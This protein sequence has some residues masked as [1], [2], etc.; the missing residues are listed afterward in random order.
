MAITNLW[1][2]KRNV[3][4]AVCVSN[5]TE[6]RAVNKEGVVNN[7]FIIDVLAETVRE[8]EFSFAEKYNDFLIDCYYMGPISMFRTFFFQD[9]KVERTPVY[10]VNNETEKIVATEDWECTY[11]TKYFIPGFDACNLIEGE[12]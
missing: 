3:F 5:K 11:R 10:Y 8:T 4:C 12:Y 6:S 1:E 2:T 9:G 7:N